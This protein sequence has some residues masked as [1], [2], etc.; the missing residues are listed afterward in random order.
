MEQVTGTV[1]CA[2]AY[3][4]GV[5]WVDASLNGKE[6][7]PSDRLNPGRTSF[8]LRQEYMAHDVTTMVKSGKNAAAILLGKGE[9]QSVICFGLFQRILPHF[10]NSNLPCCMHFF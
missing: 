2:T 5:G 10:S 7:A 3:V 6:I 9:K 8:N 1:T 4:S